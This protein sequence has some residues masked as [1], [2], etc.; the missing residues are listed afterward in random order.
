[1]TYLD[2]WVNFVSRR[3]TAVL[4]PGARREEKQTN[5]TGH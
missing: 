2:F 4:E 3:S 1:M 5:V